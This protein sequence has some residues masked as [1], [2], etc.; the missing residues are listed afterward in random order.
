[1]IEVRCNSIVI[2]NVSQNSTQRQLDK[3]EHMFTAYDMV[4]HEPS[5]TAYTQI[6][7]DIYLP[8]TIPAETIS[9]IFQY[10]M[11]KRID[12]MPEGKP[13]T[14]SM[15][16]DCRSD[17]QRK[18]FEFIVGIKDDSASNH[19]MLNL[20]TGKG[21]TF[22]AIKSIAEI[23]LLPMIVVDSSELANQWVRQFVKHT[24]LVKDD[25]CVI[26]GMFMAEACKAKP[27]K[28]FIALHKTL[29]M[30]LEKDPSSVNAL[31]KDLGVGIRVF[32]EAHSN[33]RSICEIVALSSCRYN[34]Y[35]TA[36]PDRSAISE[37]RLY[38]L[39]FKSVP[40]YV[41]E[42]VEKYHEVVFGHIDSRPSYSDTQKVLS[43]YGFSI[44]LWSNYISDKRY[45]YFI[46]SLDKLIKTLRLDER[47]RKV[48]F[49]FPTI[50]LIEA[51]KEHMIK[52]YPTIQ[53]GTFIA[54]VDKDVRY[55]ELQKQFIITDDKIFDKAID[56]PDLEVLINFVPLTSTVKLEQIIGRLRDVE[57]RAHVYVDIA[58][59]GFP[60]C[61]RQQDLRKRYYIKKAD[62]VF[63]MDIDPL[64]DPFDDYGQCDDVKEG[65]KQ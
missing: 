20:F 11:T 41:S 5:L 23:G 34:V 28:A 55:F 4:T 45:S 38:K 43:K 9:G 62:K 47:N 48:A 26:S 65:T 24:D 18:A 12:D 52:A 29:N 6:G 3:F 25:I 58:D 53:I 13:V 21:K 59:Y 14:F 7:D 49:M 22:V 51:V 36:T 64:P 46:R 1:M 31:I 15:K 39:V 10:K 33:F 50:R 54:K 16:S 44:P 2:R 61:R 37:K 57:G 17:E 56:I 40:K 35:L 8:G 19:R 63:D 30:M 32:D 27:Y 60:Q 42:D